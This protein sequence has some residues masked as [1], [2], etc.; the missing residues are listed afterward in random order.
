V[1]SLLVVSIDRIFAV[2][3]EPSLISFEAI[4]EPK[5]CFGPSFLGRG[6]GLQ[7]LEETSMKM[8]PIH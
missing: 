4:F 3:R 8:I 6:E 1:K 2:K 7:R 5:S